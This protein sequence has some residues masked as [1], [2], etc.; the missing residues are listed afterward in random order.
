[1]NI[2][3][4]DLEFEPL[5]AYE[6]IQKRT[7]EIAAQLNADYA[8]KAPIF[9]GVL[10]GAFMFFADLLNHRRVASRNRAISPEKD[11]HDNFAGI[12]CERIDDASFQINRGLSRGES[13]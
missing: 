2:K 9:V 4:A 13:G 6:T 10:N 12:H 7:A 5:I 1:M 11:Q 8:D 3:I